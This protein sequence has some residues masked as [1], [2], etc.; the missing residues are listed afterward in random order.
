MSLFIVVVHTIIDCEHPHPLWNVTGYPE[1]FQSNPHLYPSKPAPASTG[2]GFHGHG[3]RVYKNPWELQPAWGYA[4]RDD[5][6][7]SQGQCKCQ[8]TLPCSL[9][10]IRKSFGQVVSWVFSWVVSRNSRVV[11]ARGGRLTLR[12]SSCLLWH[13]VGRFSHSPP[14]PPPSL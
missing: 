12:W 9:A 3:S 10:R 2:M 6:W 11:F 13:G 7:T 8:W 4:F 5:Q 1:V 14:L